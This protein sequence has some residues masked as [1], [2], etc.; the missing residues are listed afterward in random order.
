MVAAVQWLAAGFRQRTGIET[1]VHTSCKID[2]HDKDLQLVAF[3][4]A[5]EALTN[6]SKYAKCTQVEIDLADSEGHLTLEVR[7]NGQGIQQT[8]LIKPKAVGISGL[9]ERAKTVGGWLD[10]SSR[11]G[12]GTAIILSAPLKSSN[13]LQEQDG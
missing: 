7:V 1:Y 5:Q 13:M 6:I 3:R 9:R 11:P 2:I 4:T 8:D 10:V 12:S